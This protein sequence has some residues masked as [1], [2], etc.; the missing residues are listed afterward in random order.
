MRR[1]SI[2]APL[3][4]CCVLIIFACA[5]R[6]D[7]Q[8]TVLAHYMPWYATKPVSGIWGW[9]WTMGHFDPEQVDAA[10]RPE[11][12]THDP[13]L[14]GL[15]D[16]GDPHAL[17]CQVQLMK[18]AG[19]DGVIVDWYGT[20]EFRDYA[21]I[22]RNTEKLIA[23]I[24]RAGLKFA[25]CYEDQTVKHMVEND[26]I[27]P[28]QAVEEGARSL[29]WLD[30]H[31][32]SDEAYVRVDGQ[33]ILLVFGPQYFSRE[34]WSTLLGGLTHRPLLYSLPHLAEKSGADG[35]FGWPPVTGG[36]EIT[37]ATWKKSLRELA[38]REVSGERILPVAFPGFRDIY[39]QA[40]LHD[41]YGSIDDRD[42]RTFAESYALAWE[43]DA[44]VIQLAT[45]N[46]YGEGTVIEPTVGHGYRDLEFLLKDIRRRRP[47]RAPILTDD[48]TLPVRLYRARKALQDDASAQQ[49]LN[50]AAAFL[51]DL[52]IEKARDLIIQ[53]ESRLK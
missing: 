25:I 38:R 2:L 39:Q 34:Q 49:Q 43:T 35:A 46:D 47:D 6:A 48:L 3:S 29:R 50:E 30:E 28:E 23:T 18:L 37:S 14:I 12:A 33:P 1:R 32:F 41:S 7:D 24:H 40:G 16:S 8:K 19:I 36:R 15:Y 20:T 31:W 45:W 11:A 53:A 52:R 13:P 4:F 27:L 9:H 5:V 21:V 26:F 22:H 17:D 51:F 10:G 44:P 42:G